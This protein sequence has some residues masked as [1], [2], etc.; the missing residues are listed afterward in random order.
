MTAPGTVEIMSRHV[1]SRHV[2]WRSGAG[3]DG[4]DPLELPG[5]VVVPAAFAAGAVPFSNLTA[6]LL[7]GIDLRSV[8]S[9]TVSGTG[10][11]RVAGFRALAAAGVLEVAK[12]M[13]GP[14]L[15]G[16]R[17]PCLAALASAAGVAGHNW[18]PF[19]RGAGGRGL[20]PALGA[21]LVGAPAG[22]AALLAGM[23]AG[24]AAGETAVGSLVGDL[25]SVVVSKRA[26][27]PHAAVLATAVLVP[28]VAKRLAGNGPPRSGG[29]DT[30]LWRLACDRDSRVPSRAAGDG[31]VGR[32]TPRAQP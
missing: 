24:R 9:G 18:S 12:G 5:W 28:V 16:P 2:M 1:S 10:L 27:G 15:S 29:F 32:K 8:G 19:L 23:A 22:S 14:V 6:R 21:M 25:L 17:R 31:G 11:Y 3:G 4:G 26:H 13:V 20:S 7:R 30:Y